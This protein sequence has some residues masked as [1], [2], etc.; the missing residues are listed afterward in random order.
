MKQVI[1]FHQL[2]NLNPFNYV[3]VTEMYSRIRLVHSHKK[4]INYIIK[5]ALA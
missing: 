4:E 5:N 3:D 1:L 2:L